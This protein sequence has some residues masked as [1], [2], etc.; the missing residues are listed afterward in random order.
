MFIDLRFYESR[1]TVVAKCKTKV[2]AN[3]SDR[4]LTVVKKGVEELDL[5]LKEKMQQMML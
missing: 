3:K 1:E 4:L 2:I 5:E